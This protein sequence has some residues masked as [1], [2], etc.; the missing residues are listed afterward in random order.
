M[1]LARP[2]IAAILAIALT[3]LKQTSGSS[4]QST[5]AQNP[6]VQEV[7]VGSSPRGADL[8]KLLQIPAEIEP[9]LR[10]TLTLNGDSKGLGP[11]RYSLR[12]E[13]HPTAGAQRM[14]NKEGAWTTTRGT[15]SNPDAVV[16]D[17]E[18]AFSLLKVG[19]NVLH[20]L[21]RDRS[22]MTG[23]AGWSYSLNRSGFLDDPGNLSVA[24]A[25]ASESYT[26][27]P[28]ASGPS[29]FG[30]FNGR[31]P[32]QGIRR[33]L[34]L[35]PDAGCLKIKWRITLFQNPETCA[36]TTYKI[37]SS[38]HR[39]GKQG[40]REGT[41]TIVRGTE[42]DPKAVLYRLAPTKTEPA[43]LL[44]KGD[45]NVLFILDEKQKPLVGTA[46]FSYTFNRKDPAE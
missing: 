8:S 9:P 2:P 30:I 27:S 5:S 38:L 45:D 16:Y 22:L 12:C 3:F 20:I 4:A 10:W 29:V 40:T 19:E 32:G 39:P 15:K 24:L 6:A 41:W 34:K 42:A 17:L 26:L 46:D 7:F 28:L 33:E 31:T 25:R 14:V 36:P 18:G 35:F 37:E 44:L 11:A 1:C 13:Y 21:N 43:L 23:S